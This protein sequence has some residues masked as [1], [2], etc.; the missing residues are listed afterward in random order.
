MDKR[1]TD[2]KSDS[3]SSES[4]DRTKG[5][6]PSTAPN[7]SDAGEK[8]LGFD[9]PA[10]TSSDL[11]NTDVGGPE[12]GKP[13]FPPGGAPELERRGREQGGP[14]PGATPEQERSRREKGGSRS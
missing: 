7:N 3:Q 10:V 8:A 11:P 2:Y 1:K 14:H 12:L 6:T 4:Q 13:Y 5:K 9:S